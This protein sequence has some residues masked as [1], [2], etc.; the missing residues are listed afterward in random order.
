MK[1]Y[2][3]QCRHYMNSLQLVANKITLIDH[4]QH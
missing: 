2:W 3:V 1:W 4:S